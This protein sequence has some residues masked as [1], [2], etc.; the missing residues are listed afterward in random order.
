MYRRHTLL[1][2][3]VGIFMVGALL[4]WLAGCGGPGPGDPARGARLFSGELAFTSPQAPIC[5]TCHGI[6]P[7]EGILL[8]PN[9]AGIGTVAATRVPD[10]SAEQYLRTALLDPDAYL[11]DGFQEGIMY[12]A[13]ARDLTP[14]EINDL[15]A[16][17]LTLQ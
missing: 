14:Q 15:I 13:Y 6:D 3:R 7:A 12:R 11:V 4:G 5:A 16:Y 1:R 8:G 2:C 10:Q 17:L 9:L